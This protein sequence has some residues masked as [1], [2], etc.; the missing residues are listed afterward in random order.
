SGSSWRIPSTLAR[1]SI[2][3]APMLWSH[4]N[5]RKTSAWLSLDVDTI[6]STPLNVASASSMGRVI[7]L[8]TSSGVEPSYG[9]WMNIPGN[10]MSGNFS[11]GRSRDAIRPTR[12]SATNITKVV[13]GRLTA[14]SVCLIASAARR[15]RK[16][17]CH[18][19]RGV[20]LAVEQRVH[21]RDHYQ[22]QYR[23]RQHPA[24]DGNRHWCPHFGALAEPNCHRQQAENRRQRGHEDRTKAGTSCRHDRHGFL[25][26]LGAQLVDQVHQH[27]RVV[28]DNPGEHDHA[29]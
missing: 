2:P 14:I 10:S 18:L 27:D 21:H 19:E 16:V 11:S 4:P 25:H 9:T 12:A 23:R 6:L 28:D 13:T 26:P 15:C 7:S 1:A 8:S 3:F 24:D 29:D 5:S 20:F 17:G 22:R